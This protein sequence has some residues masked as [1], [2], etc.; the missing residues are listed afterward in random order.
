MNGKA[1]QVLVAEGVVR[2]PRPGDLHAAGVRWAGLR[3]GRREVV[4]LLGPPGSGKS[5]LL[6]ICGG[7]DRQDSGDVRLNGRDLAALDDHERRTLLQRDVGWVFQ[8]PMLVPVLTAAENVAIAMRIAGERAE[9]ADR[10]TLAA[11]DAVGLEHR[12]G[13]LADELSRG[14][15]QRVALARA[16]VKAPALVIADEPTAQLDPASASEIVGLLRDAA[17]SEVAVLFSTHDEAEAARA[18]RVLLMSG[19]TLQEPP[20]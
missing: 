14:E 12:A 10:M 4:A 9:D 1:P 2:S 15:G 3:V 17:R 7:L 11:L 8:T 13:R 20:S 18:D 6:A 5:A 16:L 19:G